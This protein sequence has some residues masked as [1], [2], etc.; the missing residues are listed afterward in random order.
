MPDSLR[1]TNWLG[2]AGPCPVHGTPLTKVQAHASNLC[3]YRCDHPDC[4]PVAVAS[5]LGQYLLAGVLNGLP[6]PRFTPDG[7]EADCPCCGH[8]VLVGFH[9]YLPEAFPLLIREVPPDGGFRE[10]CLWGPEI[11]EKEGR[12][13][14]AIKLAEE[15]DN[16][17]RDARSEAEET[18]YRARYQHGDT[19][20]VTT[21]AAQHH[22]EV[23]ARCESTRAV[24]ASAWAEYHGYLKDTRLRVPVTIA[25]Q[26]E[27]AALD[28]YLSL[29]DDPEAEAFLAGME[30]TVFEEAGRLL[31]A[32]NQTYC[33]CSQE[34][35]L[36]KI[37]L[38]AD[39]ARWD[40]WPEYWEGYDKP[41]RGGPAPDFPGFP[42]NNPD[43]ASGKFDGVTSASNR[44]CDATGIFQDKKDGAVAGGPGLGW[45]PLK[46]LEA[47]VK[48][49]AFPADVFPEALR[50]YAEEGARVIGCPVD[51]IAGS[52]LS[53]AG[54]AVG[55]SRKLILKGTDEKGYAE[56]ANLWVCLVGPPGSSKTPA[57]NE[58]VKPLKVIA[59]EEFALWEPG[60]KPLRQVW[61]ADVTTEAMGRVLKDNPKGVL[62]HRDE[63]VGWV[64]SMDQYKG[65]KGGDRQFYLSAWSREPIHHLRKGDYEAGPVYVPAPF[66]GVLGGLPTDQLHQLISHET[67]GDGFL[68]RM[69]FIHPAEVP[70]AKWAS[71]DISA[72]AREAWVAVV[73]EL[74]ALPDDQA[75]SVRFSPAAE[76]R[77]A[78]LYDG[79]A[80]EMDDRGLDPHL[81]NV[82]SKLRAYAGRLTLLLHVLHHGKAGVEVGPESVE[83]AW[84]LV[85]YFKSHARRVYGVMSAAETIKQAK[86]IM[87]WARRKGVTSF[88]RSEAFDYVKNKTLAKS[89]DLILPLQVL[90]A[91]G[92]VRR[93]VVTDPKRGRPADQYNVNPLVLR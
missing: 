49:E 38:S 4:E 2:I 18:W 33:R 20:V 88:T 81:R 79:H 25:D 21:R 78:E 12:L 14:D 76:A 47:E 85:S 84:R 29:T 60:A 56:S 55:S 8:P 28:K 6:K 91:Y 17:A 62:L 19:N 67:E 15:K 31:D 42:G 89:D 59:G 7:I 66:L 65:G 92:H 48:V 37:G 61:V 52:M 82:W 35:I 70:L 5:A 86:R 10:I 50:H 44:T 45:P 39:R 36:E 57:M 51:Y 87:E 32:Y 73:S 11:S 69:L 3:S 80:D 46:P 1:E 54:V 74:W 34:E 13:L 30:R 75:V 53:V 16:E 83:G 40:A 43:D 63:L 71:D 41:P 23:S 64:R 72:A 9:Y 77:W 90:E 27:K 68:D 24:L 22:K 93:V 26:A 58:A